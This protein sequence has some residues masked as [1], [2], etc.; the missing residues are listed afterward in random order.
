MIEILVSLIA[1]IVV[2]WCIVLIVDGQYD[3]PKKKPKNKGYVNP[4][5]Q[6][7]YKYPKKAQT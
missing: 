2:T 1:G 3:P 4:Y 5:S 6:L 7:R